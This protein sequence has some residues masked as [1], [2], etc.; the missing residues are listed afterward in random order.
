MHELVEGEIP[1]LEVS[2]VSEMR[3]Y[4]L[5]HV[6]RMQRDLELELLCKV[7]MKLYKLFAL[8]SVSLAVLLTIEVLLNHRKVLLLDFIIWFGQSSSAE[9]Y[10]AVPGVKFFLGNLLAC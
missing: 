7:G 6:L 3:M 4:H 10:V 9:F 1:V 5:L 8:Y 2:Q